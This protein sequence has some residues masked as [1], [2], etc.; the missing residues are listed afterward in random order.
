MRKYG[1][2]FI[3]FSLAGFSAAAQEF[4]VAFQHAQQPITVVSAA[5]FPVYN[6]LEIAVANDG[7]TY[8]T[9]FFKG[10]CDFNPAA[11][12]NLNLTSLSNTD[13][14]VF[15][16]KLDAAGNFVYAIHL[17]GPGNARGND[18]IVTS[19]G[20]IIVVGFFSGTLNFDPGKSNFSIS[21]SGGNDGFIAQYDTETGTFENAYTLGG[22]GS[23][24][25]NRVTRA[26]TSIYI[27]GSFQQ[28]VDF[29]LAA[30]FNEV[31]A[32][33][34]TQVFAAC[35]NDSFNF[36]WVNDFTSTNSVYSISSLAANASG[37][38]LTGPFSGT[39]DFD[40][41]AATV[42]K[43]TAG[44]NDV[45][46][47]KFDVLTGN[48]VWNQTFG[49]TTE[50]R[51]IDLALDASSN[52]FITGFFTGTTD[53]DP[54]G[55][56]VSATSV[57]F[58][59][60]FLSKLDP[61]GNLLWSRT[62]GGANADYSQS[63]ALISNGGVVVGGYFYSP[64]LDANPGAG[65]NTFTRAHGTDADGYFST[66]DAA[67]TFTFG[68]SFGSTNE[69]I[70]GNFES[71]FVRSNGDRFFSLFGAFNN[72]IDFDPTTAVGELTA[73]YIDFQQGYVA[74]YAVLATLP[75]AQPTALTLSNQTGSSIDVSFTGS[76]ANG[77][78]VVRRAGVASTSVPKDGQPYTA[79]EF[80]EDGIITYAGPS[81]SFTDTNLAANTNYHYKVFAYND[82][83]GEVNYLT[84]AP[85]TGSS[86]TTALTY[87]I[88]TDSLA[89]IA[90]YNATNGAGWIN[91]ANWFSGNVSTWYGVTVRGNRVAKLVLGSNQLLGALPASIGNLTALDT[92]ELWNNQL[93]GNLPSE[94]G[95]ITS[96]DYMDLSP[97]EF[98]GAIPPE[99]GNLNALVTLWLNNN[100]L[101][102]NIPT[103]L[104]NLSSLQNL[105][106]QGNQLSG[107]I[108]ISLGS[109]SQLRLLNASQNLLTGSIP[110]ELG[111]LSLLTTLNLGI[112]QLSGTI[113]VQLGSLSALQTLRLDQNKLTGGIPTEL[114]NVSALVNLYLNGNQLTGT[115]PTQLGNL[116][117]LVFMD[118]GGNQL[119]GSIPAGLFSIAGLQV[120]GIARNQLTGSIPTEITNATNLIN[121]W[122]D[123]NQLTGAF[124]AMTS[125]T[126]PAIDGITIDRNQ[127]SDLPNLSSL[128]GVLSY[129]SVN[130]NNFTFE[131][132]EP[133][134]GISGIS[135]APQ[136]NIGLS[137]TL[138]LNA[139]SALNLSYTVGGTANA[140][141]WRLNN[142]ND[143]TYQTNT[144][145]I[146]AVVPTNN[147]NWQLVTTNSLVPSLTILSNAV[148]VIVKAEG[149]FTW[150]DGGDLTLD[151]GK[152]GS[153]G[154]A[155]GD[156]DND[157]FEDIFTMGFS[158]TLRN[159]LY[160]NNGNGT[161][162]R[163]PA[164]NFHL[165]TGRN[166]TWAD[167]NN[168]GLLDVYVPNQVGTTINNGLSA[169]YKNT[170]AGNFTKI[171][172]PTVG[173][174]GSWADLDSDGDLDLVITANGGTQE[175]F[176]R[177]NGND[178]FERV[179]NVI[180]DDTQW[181]PYFV[182]VNN[183]SRLD[184]FITSV[185][186]N[187]ALTRLFINDDGLSNFYETPLPATYFGTGPR[188][189][190][191]A[192][193][194]NDG[195]YDLYLMLSNGGPENMFYIN[196]GYGNFT[197]ELGS[198]RL[199]EVV[200]G[201]RGSAFGDLNNDGYVD[202]VTY[203]N[204]VAPNGWTVYLNNGNGTFARALNQTFKEVAAFEGVSLAD[205]DND[206]F[207]D[208]MSAT[209]AAG[210]TFGLYKNTGNSNHWLKVK[211][212]GSTTNR[213]GI[214]ARIAV[215]A[216][217][218]WRHHQVITTNGFGNQNSLLAHFGMGA[219]TTA[220]SIVVLW[221]SGYEQ[222]LLNQ[223]AD[224][225]LV[226][227]EPPNPI[228]NT[229]MEV[230]AAYQI[231]SQNAQSFSS[232]DDFTL[233]GSD[234]V[235][236]AGF[237][238][239]TVDF[240]PGA[241]NVILNT[242]ANQEGFIA[243]YGS[244]GSLG[245]V[246]AFPQ[247]SEENYAKVETI[248]ADAAG[249]VVVGG[250]VHGTYDVNPG[251]GVTNLSSN[252][253]TLSDPYFAKYTAGGTF[254]WAKQF[255][256]NSPSYAYASVESIH[257]DAANNIVV[258]G[259]FGDGTLDMDPSGATANLTSSDTFEDIFLAKYDPDGNY[260]WSVAIGSVGIYEFEPTVIIDSQNNIYLAYGT[261]EIPRKQILSKYNAGG[262]LVW[263]TTNTNVDG[264]GFKQ[265][266]LE[267][268]SNR[269]FVLGT[270]RGNPSFVGTSGNGVLP[271]SPSDSDAG[272]VAAYDLNGAYVTAYGFSTSQ[273]I[274]PVS[275]NILDD[276]NLLITGGYDGMVDLDPSS[277]I[278]E[279]YYL[280][281]SFVTKITPAGSLIWAGSIPNSYGLVSELNSQ[282]ELTTVLLFGDKTVD[283][284]PGPGVLNLTALST[285]E[286]FSIIRYDI[287]GGILS[288]DSLALEEFYLAT[289]GPNW[290]T[291]TNWLSGNVA[292]WFGVTVT[293]DRITAINLP[294]N[295]LTGAVPEGS[296]ILNDL[297]NLNISGNNLVAV[298]DFSGLGATPTIDLSNNRLD[299]G[300]LE[301]NMDVVGIN[302]L[303][304][305]P[306]TIAPDS[307]LVES[308]TDY[309][310]NTTLGGTA[311]SYQWQ[312]NTV[313]IP[314]AVADSV[315]VANISRANMG[316]YTLSVTNSL[317]PNLTLTTVPVSILATANLTGK[318]LLP[319]APASAGI[320]RLFRVTSS[321][322]Y[323]TIRTQTIS[324]TGDY[325]FNQVVLD[326]YQIV[327]FA[328]T[329]VV[330]QERALP[331]YYDNTIYWEEAD[332]LFVE[333]SLG[334]LDILSLL[335]PTEAL[336]GSGEITGTLL[337]DDGTGARIEKTKRVGGA[338]VS[339]RRVQ[340]TGRG[341]ELGP[342]LAY[343]FTDEDGFF[344]LPKL[345]VGVYRI[346][347]QYPGYPM[348][349]NSFIDIPIG[350]TA[351][352]ERVSVEAL[353]A[354]GKIS[355]RQLI[356]TGIEQ[357][358]Y[359]ADVYPNPTS[360]SVLVS[361]EK[362]ATERTLEL[363]DMQ[364]HQISVNIANE[365]SVHVAMNTLEPGLYLLK[366][367]EQGRPMKTIRISVQR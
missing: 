45:W 187:P 239:G 79:N 130:N 242:S 310:L 206:G 318:L 203:Q 351:L 175:S 125:S 336:T 328:D 86:S 163:Q 114:G 315:V 304:Q 350:S 17:S 357:G 291:K 119:T 250:E 191:W 260:V 29:D 297:T 91:S 169:I 90:L 167:Y 340:G 270:Y 244:D 60:A 142:V 47:S 216:D 199:G 170:G 308:G 118:L 238:Q 166:V 19:T 4:P 101:T 2:F 362:T 20:K 320:V 325:A 151:G 233:D 133:N 143:S 81:T 127:L 137:D 117:N 333:N 288:A 334:D 126:N 158:D 331:T 251:A 266:K 141:V 84:A 49:G 252:V 330:G 53:L 296:L 228:S 332:T 27:S 97:N 100:K 104:G 309:T 116:S 1:W 136:N 69:S 153:Y 292:T 40:P 178:V 247:A 26:D 337:E 278:Y 44:G 78:L 174:S 219:V 88:Q 226:I 123:T 363:L 140:Y 264:S 352:D 62:W 227:N 344:V 326:D 65:T 185:T 76:G 64:S 30:G 39:V 6:T 321:E 106:L 222:I 107:S 367:M 314:T 295:N 5:G 74:R 108:P 80:L 124:P 176:F 311:N 254:V 218:F 77:Y 51:A 11:T 217:G 303:N 134:A 164:G 348:D 186:S 281:S 109:L 33:A 146:P 161:F 277:G 207:V 212:N 232:L 67:G 258:A 231:R 46:I 168:D 113:P 7:S 184:Y 341:A 235:L 9:G 182:D 354:E 204:T 148:R 301:Y 165:G 248:Q 28:T 115:I 289:G 339:A 257:A 36:R 193:I 154:G 112:N 324:A 105:Y 85:L 66:F 188:G 346:N 14:D 224:Q 299:F 93:T 209:F 284:E 120:V 265:L 272:Y 181:T 255:L 15:I 95:S 230:I 313:A 195:D 18:M 131:D 56:V 306:L 179:D 214:G 205:Y 241:G 144:L 215:K 59:D 189:A 139:G 138:T 75:A 34:A 361:F 157:G 267:E 21:S 353:V 220:D 285:S 180:N 8:A 196:D 155:W 24:V 211:L 358:E 50:D 338:G 3:A 229:D 240:D 83:N 160:K 135:Y 359:P 221:P 293:N 132:L 10:T 172:L 356:I 249:N 280:E 201:G 360:S 237:Y 57:G 58:D 129:M 276:G 13:E 263:T 87:S 256:L 200:R 283:A 345:P 98:T 366:V 41:S 89:L 275:V 302:Y 347:I 149:V 294:N 298:P 72:K 327:G 145:N 268:A 32:T 192:D 208:M 31:T 305:K 316:S 261:D 25:V 16:S 271:F 173:G 307:I 110:V 159:Y 23:D 329:L 94:L 61:N 156:Y 54:S 128:N 234:N 253:A 319:A 190:S 349:P 282:N 152:G 342:L 52:I 317:V 111:N 225:T 335:E 210:T 290:A 300:S 269:L 243:K 365:K 236:V 37:V 246:Y 279:T 63:V 323:D 121:F 198:I 48:L 273:E 68:Y 35:Y 73:Q 197:E 177:N 183:D 102:G 12:A 343:V 99:L 312:R 22:A 147:G 322:G 70:S 42:S 71:A 259:H 194:D 286:D 274:F 245:W 355:V 43:T 122:A 171:N 364:G 213:G 103:T 262:T 38:Y 162:T 82:T 55:A 287:Q 92:L 150:A 223:G 96:L 202:L